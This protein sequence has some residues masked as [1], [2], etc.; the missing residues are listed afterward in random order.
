MPNIDIDNGQPVRIPALQ[1]T[2]GRPFQGVVRASDGETIMLDLDERE[3]GEMPE[4]PDT[5]AMLVWEVEGMPGCGD[6]PRSGE[7]NR[8]LLAPLL[9]IVTRSG[10][11]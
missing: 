4:K 11:G 2:S 9:Q 8:V 1:L 5:T 3:K 7:P 6:R 10:E